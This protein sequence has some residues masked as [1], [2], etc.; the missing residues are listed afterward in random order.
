MTDSLKS[1]PTLL[2][3][4]QSRSGSIGRGT[5]LLNGRF[6]LEER[7]GGGGM[8][9][10]FQAIE[11][12]AARLEDRRHGVPVVS[13]ASKSTELARTTLVGDIANTSVISDLVYPA[14]CAVFAS[15]RRPV[16]CVLSAVR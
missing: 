16:S 9:E 10:I 3:T 11:L 13:M 6:E 1:A 5:R 4:P 14:F 15:V 7:L 2:R 12:E 8:G